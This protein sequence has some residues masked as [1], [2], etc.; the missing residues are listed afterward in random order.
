M[1]PLEMD[2]FIE[3]GSMNLWN[4]TV[5]RLLI[6]SGPTVLTLVNDF[7]KGC[8]QNVSNPVRI[9]VRG[10][11]RFNT[12]YPKFY[13]DEDGA[14]GADKI[15]SPWATSTHLQLRRRQLQILQCS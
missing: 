10:Y 14:Y 1:V 2:R 5:Y 11:K 15:F 9:R 13:C 6:R 4:L 3:I 12:K 8:H 7:P